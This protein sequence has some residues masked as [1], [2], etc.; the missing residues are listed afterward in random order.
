MSSL[1]RRTPLRAKKRI[2]SKPKGK[3]N[4]GE[5]E[6]IE[7]LKAHGWSGARRNFAS[8]GYGGSDTVGGPEGCAIEV[9]RCERAEIWKWIA[10]CVAAARPTE[11]PIVVFRR[12]HSD[13]QACLPLEDLLPLLALREKG[14]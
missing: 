12:S 7:I 10:Q 14:L 13:W 6:V 4:R 9:K 3:G 1:Q 8:G 11:I 5:A 2:V